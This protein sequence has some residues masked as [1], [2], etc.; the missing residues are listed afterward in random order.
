MADQFR[1]E[2]IEFGLDHVEDPPWLRGDRRVADLVLSMLADRM[3][4]N[5]IG[6]VGTD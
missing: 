6:I 4:M 5:R 1:S 2:L 3:A